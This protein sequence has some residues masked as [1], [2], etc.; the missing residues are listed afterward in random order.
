MEVEAEASRLEEEHL[1]LEPEQMKVAEE[2]QKKLGG[3]V[4]SSARW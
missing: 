2:E 3:S 4:R 1:E